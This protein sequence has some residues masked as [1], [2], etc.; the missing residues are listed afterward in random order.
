MY[1]HTHTRLGALNVEVKVMRHCRQTKALTHSNMLS[2]CYR[3]QAGSDCSSRSHDLFNVMDNSLQRTLCIMHK[4]QSSTM[5]MTLKQ[6]DKLKH[7]VESMR[8]W[9]LLKIIAGVSFPAQWFSRLRKRSNR[10]SSSTHMRHDS[11][12]TSTSLWELRRWESLGESLAWMVAMMLACF[13]I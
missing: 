4:H 2:M 8:C 5:C 1:I 3:L 11:Y 12:C 9:C 6:F 10:S 7:Q 13:E